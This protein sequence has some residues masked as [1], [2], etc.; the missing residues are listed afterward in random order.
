MVK[1]FKL[2]KLRK[3]MYI[4]DSR[5]VVWGSLGWGQNPFLELKIGK[6]GAQN[7]Q[8]R[9]SKSVFLA[10]LIFSFSLHGV[11]GR[12]G[13][14]SGADRHVVS[15]FAWGGGAVA[16]NITRKIFRAEGAYKI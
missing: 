2:M 4:V 13:A 11:W 10:P 14:S 1:L 7:G 12:G 6:I 15:D 9:I 8:I 16:P 3:C 5:H